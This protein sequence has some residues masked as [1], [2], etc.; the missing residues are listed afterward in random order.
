LTQRQKQIYEFIKQSIKE[1]GYAPS[2]E[3]I[4]KNF[5][6]KSVSTVHEHIETL[7]A[8]GVL[9]KI[10]N[11]A[12]AI[13]IFDSESMI[14]I[15]I[16]GNIAAGQPIEAM[17]NKEMM[18]VPKSKLP[19]VGEFYALRVVGDSMIDENIN[20]GDLVLVK[21]QDT[22]ENGQKV[23]ALIDNHEA[24]LKTFYKEKSF[25]R[26]QPAN[27]EYDP[28]IIKKGRELAI[29]GIIIDV[30]RN[31]EEIQA[32]KLLESKE[33]KRS[34]TLPLNKIILGDAVKELKKLP[35]ESCDVIICDPPYNIGKDFGNNHDR[36]ELKEY[37]T[38]CK[39]WINESIRVMKPAGTMFIYGFSEILAYLSVEIPI[40][41][42]WLI[43][44]YTNKNVASLNFWQRSHEAIICAWKDKSVFNRDEIREPYTEGF[45]NGA[46]GKVRRGTAG[47][48]SSNGKET[49][50]NAHEGGA[51]PRD[52]IKIPALAGGAGMN[53]RWFIC[54]TCKG[55]VFKPRELKKH[56]DHEIIK[57]PTQKPLELSRKLVMSAMPKKD[58]VVLVPFVGTGSECVAAKILGQSYIGFEINPDYIKL[59]EKYLENTKYIPKLF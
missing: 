11:Q 5:K 42:R 30:I 13:N 48:Y 38:W 58:G 14:Q 51:L 4:K 55:Q 26:L 12:R 27:K 37:I 6:L 59:T 22:A 2:L 54:K 36:R 7:R 53:E 29:Q 56:A 32:E 47:R 9:N 1:N 8:K 57:H 31:E 49:I 28:I 46:A 3:E 10:G 40:N 16:L 25:I 44:H 20:N 21:Q 34:K 41:K 33:I 15:N 23:V 43:W 17:Q 39:E 35:D 50:Y 24:T 45:L 18:A 19:R 52:V